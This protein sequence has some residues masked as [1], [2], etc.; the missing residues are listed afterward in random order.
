M[1]NFCSPNI[2]VMWYTKQEVSIS[3]S[4]NYSGSVLAFDAKEESAGLEIEGPRDSYPA[5]KQNPT[6]IY[7]LPVCLS[8][9]RFFLKWLYMPT[10][11]M[12]NVVLR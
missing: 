3:T 11:A 2:V 1:Q 8:I 10:H 6:E 4:Q 7:S 5:A 12:S 9:T